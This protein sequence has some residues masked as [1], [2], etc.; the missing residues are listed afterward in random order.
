MRGAAEELEKLSSG[1]EENTDGPCLIEKSQFRNKLGFEILIGMGTELVGN[2]ICTA[3][4]F[5]HGVQPEEHGDVSVHN[6]AFV[7]QKGSWVR[8]QCWSE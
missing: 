6:I 2:L 3:L 1:E 7:F 5:L 4:L 8:G